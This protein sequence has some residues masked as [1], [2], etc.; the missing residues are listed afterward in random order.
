MRRSIAGCTRARRLRGSASTVS[1]RSI[2]PSSNDGWLTHRREPKSNRSRRRLRSS[3]EIESASGWR[4]EMREPLRGAADGDE[5]YLN[6]LVQ[7]VRNPAQHRQRVAFVFGVFEPANHGC[8]GADE[9]GQLRLGKV[10][11]CPQ[12]ANTA[13]DLLVG[14]RLVKIFQACR[15]PTIEAA[16]QDFHG[17]RRLS[18]TASHI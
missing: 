14:A 10:G 3:R 15:F 2:G 4:F 9:P 6:T 11:L 7:G 1:R 13:R 8:R 12:F 18:T 16:M 5:A 17:I